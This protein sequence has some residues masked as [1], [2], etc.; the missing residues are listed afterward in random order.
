[1]SHSQRSASETSGGSQEQA[2]TQ[3]SQYPGMSAEEGAAVEAYLQEMTNSVIPE[4]IEAVEERRH[5]ASL[6]RHWPLKTGG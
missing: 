2:I 6:S 5:S 3:V 4:I 1:M